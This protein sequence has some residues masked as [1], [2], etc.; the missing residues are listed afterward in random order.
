MT[1]IRQLAA[2]YPAMWYE[3]I[4][5]R[6]AFRRKQY[7]NGYTNPNFANYREH[8]ES[9]IREELAVA[10]IDAADDMARGR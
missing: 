2:K 9:D 8:A 6:L 4:H 10:A 3:E 1:F 5:E 7:A